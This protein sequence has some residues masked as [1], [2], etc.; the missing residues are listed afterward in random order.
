MAKVERIVKT[1][2]DNISISVSKREVIICVEDK[3]SKLNHSQALS[4]IRTARHFIKLMAGVREYEEE[5]TPEEDAASELE[6]VERGEREM[7]E[8]I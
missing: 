2:I 1:S 6:E 5:E 3:C 7:E 8:V 4:L